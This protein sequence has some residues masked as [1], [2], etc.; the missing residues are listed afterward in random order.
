M[1]KPCS[2]RSCS[3]RTPSPLSSPLPR[4][5]PPQGEGRKDRYVLSVAYSPDGKFIAAGAQDG[6]VAVWDAATG[7]VLSNLKGH[8]KPVRKVTFT[9][10]E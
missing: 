4:P 9:P 7:A 2:S 3:S 10:G 1:A 6:T 8:H 5:P